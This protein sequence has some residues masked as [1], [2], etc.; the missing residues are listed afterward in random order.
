MADSGPLARLE[1]FKTNEHFPE[2]VFGRVAEGQT[3]RAIARSL[4]L[5]PAPFSRWY[6]EVHGDLYDKARIARAEDLVGDALDAATADLGKDEVPAAKLKAEILMKVASK[7]DKA[8]YGDS[9]QVNKTET[10][11]IDAGLVG[12]ASD[13]IKKIGSKPGL[14]QRA[15]GH[16]TLTIDQEDDEG[17]L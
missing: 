5:P 8:R 16:Q 10:F 6:M 7:Y 3:L 15:I 12:L 11:A 14:A 1:E 17:S 13:L 4:G 9:L 2:E